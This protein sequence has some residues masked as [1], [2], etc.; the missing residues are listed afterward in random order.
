MI[1]VFFLDEQEFNGFYVAGRVEGRKVVP[2]QLNDDI[3][4]EPVLSDVQNTI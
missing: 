3:L 4:G 1:G 2:G